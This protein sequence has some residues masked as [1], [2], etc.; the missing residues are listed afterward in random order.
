MG[1]RVRRS[2]QPGGGR[3]CGSQST[4]DSHANN[5]Y[6]AWASIDTEPADT[7]PYIGP[8]FSPNRAELVVGTPISNPVVPNEQSLA[9]S[10]VTTVSV[11]NNFGPADY[12]HPQ[13]VINQNASGQVT[14]AWDDFG[15]GAKASPAFDIL[16]SSLVQAGDTYSFAGSTGGFAAAIP[17][18][19]GSTTNT[20]VTT[21]FPDL[22]RFPARV[23]SI[24]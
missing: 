6:I 21:P 12:S 9:F 3:R 17:P 2:D 23:R 20:P 18:A 15:T 16:D 22:V 19:T 13:L 7:N 8:G 14:V 5:V 11:G 1:Y 4:L 24:T 10:G